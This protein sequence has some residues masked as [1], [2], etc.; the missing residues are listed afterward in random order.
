[1][2]T[3]DNTKEAGSDEQ[4][5]TVKVWDLFVRFFHWSLVALFAI[6]FLTGDEVEW[7]HL[8]AGYAIAGLVAARIV[9]GFVGSRNSRFSNFVKGPRA[10]LTFLSQTMHLQAPRYLGHNPAGGAMVI[11]LLVLLAGLCATGFAMTTDAY[12]GSK[13]L[14]EIHETLANVTLVL[15]GLHLLGVIVASIEHG[16]SLVKAM[17]TGRKRVDVKKI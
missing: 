9:W 15:V 8:T 16:E 7:L 6:A 17:V 5:P 11:A 3:I 14:E 4:P 1:M 2:V 13:T 12:W 10:V